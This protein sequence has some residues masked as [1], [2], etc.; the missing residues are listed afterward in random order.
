MSEDAT[1]FKR[2]R[3]VVG[4]RELLRPI[5]KAWYNDG[6][7]DPQAF[8]LSSADKKDNNR[9][10]IVRGNVTTPEQAYIARAASI[11]TRCDALGKPYTPPVG[12]LA[13]TVEEVESIEL[14]SPEGSR[15]RRPLTAWDD[16]MNDDRPDDHGHVD[17]DD[18]PPSDKGA[19]LLAAKTMLA[20]AWARGWMFSPVEPAGL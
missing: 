10:S 4:E 16:S 8:N 18:V 11:K 20:M 7:V 3:I 1:L 19:S 17:F 15:S 14:E 13:V 5:I 9:L 6:V 12:V 2:E